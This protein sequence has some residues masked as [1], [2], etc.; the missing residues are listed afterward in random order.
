MAKVFN[1]FASV[2]QRK[3]LNLYM[4]IV[5]LK[6][7]VI[8]LTVL[9]HSAVPQTHKVLIR[10]SYSFIYRMSLFV[11]NAFKCWMHSGEK[12]SCC[13]VKIRV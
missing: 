6:L 11:S 13:L 10:I 7:L 4:I 12:E 5:S 2:L 1:F 3:G 8:Y 9:S